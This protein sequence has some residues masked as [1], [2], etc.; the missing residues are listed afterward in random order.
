MAEP[1]ALYLN[2]I[3]ELFNAPEFDPFSPHP[4]SISGMD[5]IIEHVKPAFHEQPFAVTI[6]L[7]AAQITAEL[8]EQVQWAVQQFSEQKISTMNHELESLRWR[9]VRALRSGLGIL[10][11]FLLLAAL[12]GQAAFLPPWLSTLLS[13]ALTIIGS[14]SLWHPAEML[15]FDWSPY[16]HAKR[17]YRLIAALHI[18]IK[19]G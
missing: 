6:F 14:V 3:H 15:L 8:P 1:L 9:G 5:S 4:R 2:S 19:A 13:E 7:P 10:G 17:V 12:A 16:W 11:L 18:E